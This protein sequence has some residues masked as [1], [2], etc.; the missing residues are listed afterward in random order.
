[1]KALF[2][3]VVVVHALLSILLTAVVLL[4]KGRDAGLSGAIAGGAQ[5]VFGKKKGQDEVLARYT[6]V[7]AILFGITSLLLTWL[8][9]K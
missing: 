5:Q 1:M 2:W 7:L 3:V 9:S 6:T 8:G 4:Q